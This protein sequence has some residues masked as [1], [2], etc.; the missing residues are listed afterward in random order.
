MFD[1]RGFLPGEPAL[2]PGLPGRLTSKL[3]AEAGVVK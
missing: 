3:L 1:L 2:P